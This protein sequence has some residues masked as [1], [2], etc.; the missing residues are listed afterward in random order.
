LL[1]GWQR[2]FFFIADYKL[3]YIK[4]ET[5]PGELTAQQM[6]EKSLLNTISLLVMQDIVI[7]SDSPQFQF[8][9]S[10]RDPRT[11]TLRSYLLR[12]DTAVERE[13][14]VNG[15]NAHREHLLS[16]LRWAS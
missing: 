9:I 3:L 10:A 12:A 11:G 6:A 7:K 8:E 4:D 1:R 14:W 16:T 5:I 2:R 15:L 13:R